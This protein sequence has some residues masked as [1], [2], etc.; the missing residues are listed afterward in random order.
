MPEAA[1]QKKRRPK[2]ADYF[3][4]LRCSGV[5]LLESN[6]DNHTALESVDST[7]AYLLRED[8][9]AGSVV[10]AREQT[11]GRGRQGRSWLARPDASLIFSGVLEF[12]GSFPLERLRLLPLLT[13]VAL[14]QVCR[15]ELERHAPEAAAQQLS[16]KWPNDLY[17]VAAGGEPRKLGG[18][19]LESRV[20]GSGSSAICRVVLGVGL[21]CCGP[22]PEPADA[23]VPAGSLYPGAL[24]GEG[25]PITRF[26]RPLVAAINRLLP[27]FHETRQ[28]QTDRGPV[29]LE[30]LRAASF[31]KDRV[32]RH[33]ENSFRVLD[34]AAGGE[35]VLEELASGRRSLLDDTSEDLQLVPCS[36]AL[37]AQPSPQA[38]RARSRAV[39]IPR[40]RCS[41]SAAGLS[42]A[43]SR[44]P[45]FCA[46]PLA[47]DFAS[48]LAIKLA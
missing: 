25:S 9:P 29:F 46:S 32:V 19:L 39:F 10:F 16:I 2:A 31:L 7:N 20:S 18:I 47:R 1:D 41:R 45:E 43:Q 6:P 8:L 3:R 5:V 33:G 28:I 23:K 21:N 13:G 36:S 22:V 37:Q 40:S 38:V 4:P 17:S 34:I 15:A 11:S 12:D 26:G 44:R 27:E 42:T 30:E 48:N 35:L 24:P 14:L